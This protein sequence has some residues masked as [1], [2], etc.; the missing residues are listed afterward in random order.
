MKRTIGG[1]HEALDR[2]LDSAVGSQRGELEG[3]ERKE[4]GDQAEGKG[5]GEIC[6]AEV[7]AARL[8]QPA[9]GRLRRSSTLPPSGLPAI[10]PTWG[11]IGSVDA[12]ASSSMPKIGER[13]ADG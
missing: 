5:L 2:L 11:E 9:M 4:Q 1:P 7:R 10:S 8:I 12:A 6:P 3:E 13:V